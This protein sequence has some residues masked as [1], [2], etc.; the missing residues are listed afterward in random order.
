MT[1]AAKDPKGFVKITGAINRE[2]RVK[3]M[4]EDGDTFSKMFISQV[5]NGDR[6]ND[7]IKIMHIKM[8]RIK[9]KRNKVIRKLIDKMIKVDEDYL[10]TIKEVTL[11]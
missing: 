8:L 1:K 7:R 9:E 2:I 5:I 11:N 6:T 3:V 4:K 10:Q